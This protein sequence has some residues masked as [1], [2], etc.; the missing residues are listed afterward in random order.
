M[1]LSAQLQADTTKILF[2]INTECMILSVVLNVFSLS[3]PFFVDIPFLLW[4]NE[5]YSLTLDVESWQTVV[6]HNLLHNRD[7]IKWVSNSAAQCGNLWSLIYL[8]GKDL[9]SP[10]ENLLQ[11]WIYSNSAVTYMYIPTEL[12]CQY[13]YLYK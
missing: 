3:T 13:P 7:R 1:V 6:Q 5:P 8:S 12:A 11:T 9:L 10:L 2:N 4:S